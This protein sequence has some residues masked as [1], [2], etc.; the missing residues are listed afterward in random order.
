MPE[1]V[2]PV[3]QMSAYERFHQLL[4]CGLSPLLR[5]E[6]F[7]GTGATFRRMKGERI[8]IVN[9]QGSRYG[10]ECC[11]NVAVHFSFLPTAGGSVPDLKKLKEYECAFRDRLHESG[12][13]DHWWTYG[14]SEAEAETSV[15][16]LI[17]MYKR[18]A[19]LFF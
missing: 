7:K 5:A 4:K 6:G 8:D 10:G 12:E 9:I 15:A 14:A 19:V 11:V 13:S 17:D 1:H 2:N 16:S 18:R 3:E